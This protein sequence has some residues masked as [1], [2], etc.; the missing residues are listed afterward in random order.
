MIASADNS[1]ISAPSSPGSPGSPG[2]LHATRPIARTAHVSRG[3]DHTWQMRIG[4]PLGKLREIRA[5]FA[6]RNR[7]ERNRYD[8]SN[9]DASNIVSRGSATRFLT[10]V[11]FVLAVN[12][13]A[14][15]SGVCGRLNNAASWS[16]KRQSDI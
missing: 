3:L 14:G 12:R 2:P 13:P 6:R 4:L 5:R 1:E 9:H 8:A 16:V 10:P 11:R 15:C 7:E